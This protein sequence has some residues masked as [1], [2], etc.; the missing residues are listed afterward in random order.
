M[1][2]NDPTGEPQVVIT[3]TA[4]ILAGLAGV[5]TAVAASIYGLGLAALVVPIH[6]EANVDWSTAFYAAALIPRVSVVGYGLT[7]FIVPFVAATVFIGVYSIV[8]AGGYLGVEGFLATLALRLGRA[9]TTAIFGV[10]GVLVS[11][12]AAVYSSYTGGLPYDWGALV[13]LVGLSGVF[14]GILGFWA[15]RYLDQASQGGEGAW[16]TLGRESRAAIIGAVLYF[17]MSALVALPY[18]AFHPLTLPGVELSKSDSVVA[19]GGLLGQSGGYWYILTINREPSDPPVLAVP[20]GE[21]EDVCIWDSPANP[22][23]NSEDI[24]KGRVRLT[25]GTD[26]C[27]YE[28]A[29]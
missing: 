19:E 1:A 24:Y 16:F 26:D 6:S 18:A 8:G 21:P 10:L 27:R 4:G 2:D 14:A 9:R 15:G 17:G 12:L 25:N 5:I 7:S 22:L 3:A 23:F 29:R 11:T 28:L 20:T 13:L